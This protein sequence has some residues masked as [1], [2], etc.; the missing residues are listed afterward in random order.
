MNT[1]L[2]LRS[3]FFWGFCVPTTWV[4]ASMLYFGLIE[5]YVGVMCVKILANVINH[6]PAFRYDNWMRKHDITRPVIAVLERIITTPKTHFIHHGYGQ[7]GRPR[8]NYGT[9]F[10]LWDIIFGTAY[11]AKGDPAKVGL[12][13][14]NKLSWGEELLYPIIRK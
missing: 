13:N 14:T 6:S 9:V 8:S 4:G 10:I 7:N 2:I 3:S 11:F 12:P 1:G 5:V